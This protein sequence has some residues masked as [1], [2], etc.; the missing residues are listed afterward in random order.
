[1]ATTLARP[2]RTPQ[3]FRQALYVPDET[4][5][6]LAHAWQVYL[7]SRESV[8]EMAVVDK[9]EPATSDGVGSVS[10]VRLN[11][12]S[13]PDRGLL[14]AALNRAFG[15]GLYQVECVVTPHPVPRHSAVPPS[16]LQRPGAC[17]V[18]H[19]ARAA[20]SPVLWGANE[21]C[22]AVVKEA[23]RIAK[24]L[25]HLWHGQVRVTCVVPACRAEC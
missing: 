3:E 2:S 19:N 1:M 16:C 18:V 20:F 4:T 14:V 22:S 5:V 8:R 6:S 10:F 17:P 7:N 13:V 21:R 11:P 24:L 9:R 15:I 25:D 12:V 23:G